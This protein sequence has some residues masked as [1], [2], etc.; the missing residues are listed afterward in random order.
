MF[1]LPEKG[2]LAKLLREREEVVRS[3]M[4][5]TEEVYRNTIVENCID[6]LKRQQQGFTRIEFLDSCL[7]LGAKLS[8]LFH[9]KSPKEIY[10]DVAQVMM[11][12]EEQTP[13]KIPNE[14]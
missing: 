11:E 14:E 2:K 9:M 1:H 5:H 13:L 3:K 7:F 4:D 12:I 8:E 10:S 6:F